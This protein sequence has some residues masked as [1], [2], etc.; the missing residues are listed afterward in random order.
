[1]RE[2]TYRQ[3]VNEAL[4]EEIERDENVF[5]MGEEVAEYEGAYKITEGLL[6]RFGDKRII[7][8]PISE[9][10]FSGLG[11]GAAMG[12]L[13][14]VVEFMTF[15][16]SLVAFDQ[17]ANNA[18]NMLTMSGGQFNI[19]ITF[20]GP[21]GPVHQLGATHS[22]AVEPLFANFPGLKICTPATPRDAKGLL[23]TAIRDNNPVLVLESEKLYGIKGEVEPEDQELLIPLGKAEVKRKGSDVTLLCYAQVVPL[24]METAEKLKEEFDVDAE[25]VDLRS[26]KPL[27]RE[28]IFKSVSKTHRV[29]V[30][31]HDKPFC[32]IGA[33]LVFEIQREIFDELDA[34]I[35]R[36]AQKEVPMPYN[37]AWENAVL[38]SAERIIE[39]V[40]RVCYL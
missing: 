24:V 34:P 13:R 32:G 19:P 26:I 7:D 12:G 15:S 21:N 9:A 17:V 8:T 35:E 3:A 10:G 31:E 23:K 29:V 37:E 33:Q 38:P 4:A 28:A 22:H 2:I 30:V 11:I 39:A 40:K 18:P 6:K 27:D 16:F 14:P 20:R 5:L 25:V 1:M 36:V